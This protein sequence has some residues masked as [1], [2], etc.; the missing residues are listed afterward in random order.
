MACA[1]NSQF[2]KEEFPLKKIVHFGAGNIGR[3]LVG[4]LF[5]AAGWEVVFVDVVE[6]VIAALNR[7]H[8]YRV[9]VKEESES[10]LWVEGVRGVDGRQ[11]ESVIQEIADCELLSTAVGPAVLPHLVPVIAQG[12]RQRNK[13]LNLLFCENLRGAPEMMRAALQNLLPPDYAFE[14]NVGLIATSIG[15]MV[16]IMPVEV[17]QRDP[18]EVWAEAYNQIIADRNG[19]LGEIPAVKGL[20][21]KNTFEAYVDQKLFVHNLGHATAA[22]QGS[23]RG[24]VTIAEAMAIPFISAST[25]GAME[26]SGQTLL[27]LYPQELTPHEMTE[28]IDDLCRRFRN[29]ALGDTV[30]RVGRDRPRKYAPHDRLIGAL[31]AHRKAQIR[32]EHTLET[33]AAGLYF[34]ATDEQGQRY[35]GDVEFDQVRDREGIEGVLKQYSGLTGADPW[36]G[37][38][39]QDI[40]R[41]VVAYQ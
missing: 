11:T 35:S 36:E 34:T 13:P 9:V 39:I 23:H 30:F 10:E 8:R 20:V 21:V 7:E 6:D 16:P 18:L 2:S 22:Y 12:L 32:S 25:H 15:K 19:F 33:I 27:Q 41:R 29:K 31:H 24:C 26:E 40:K 4:Q 28:H 38:V 1:P 3:S 14:Q 5:S 17:R 37:E